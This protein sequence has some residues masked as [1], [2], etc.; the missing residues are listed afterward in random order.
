MLFSLIFSLFLTQPV[1]ETSIIHVVDIPGTCFEDTQVVVPP[2][3]TSLG[4]L[5]GVKIDV[6]MEI[7]WALQVENLNPYGIAWGLMGW[8]PN[9]HTPHFPQE[10]GGGG[11]SYRFIRTRITGTYD[12]LAFFKRHCPVRWATNNGIRIA[13]PFDGRN[14]FE[15]PSSLNVF[16]FQ[17]MMFKGGSLRT[18]ADL[19]NLVSSPYSLDVIYGYTFWWYV[20]GT[21]MSI[22]H[23]NFQV[24]ATSAVRIEYFYV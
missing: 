3:D 23:R 7:D 11:D 22:I 19:L 6:G 15:G 1:Q 12:E 10:L 17:P 2:F 20:S 16:E 4:T 5:T 13:A 14:D 8:N 24:D 18:D 9:D 21:G